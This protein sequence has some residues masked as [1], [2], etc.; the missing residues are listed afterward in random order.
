MQRCQDFSSNAS[1]DWQNPIFWLL[2][3]GQVLCVLC[4]LD[5]G[6]SCLAHDHHESEVKALPNDLEHGSPSRLGES[7][8]NAQAQRVANSLLSRKRPHK[9]LDF[10]LWHNC[11]P[12]H[13]L[14]A[15]LYSYSDYYSNWSSQPIIGRGM[16]PAVGWPLVCSKKI[17]AGRSA[18][19][20]EG[21]RW[22]PAFGCLT[23]AKCV[24]QNNT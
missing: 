19:Q 7:S 24:I 4:V 9:L 1:L 17:V 6:T 12:L 20:W 2:V 13:D 21:T 5:S 15:S 23:T 10:V 8:V 18:V 22:Q 16:K 3:K 14:T 11:K